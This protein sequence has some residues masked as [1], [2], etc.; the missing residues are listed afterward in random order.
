MQESKK[1]YIFLAFRILIGVMFL[2]AGVEKI[3]SPFDFAVAIN[4]Y[5]IFPG[6]IIGLAAAIMPWVEALAG[7][8][9]LTGFNAKGAAT[10]TSVLLLTFVG[11][12]IISAVRG[13]DIDCGCFGSVE[14]KVGIQ[15]ILEDAALFIISASILFEKNVLTMQILF[16]KIFPRRIER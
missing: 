13:L 1:Q 4:N 3:L 16:N 14:R 12:I 15:A 9:L 8:C 5:R 7:L 6:P 10:I 11:L 2:Y